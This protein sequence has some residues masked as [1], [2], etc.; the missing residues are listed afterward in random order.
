ME[1]NSNGLWAY[2]AT[3]VEGVDIPSIFGSC[4]NENCKWFS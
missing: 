2:G 3:Y 1:H 4:E